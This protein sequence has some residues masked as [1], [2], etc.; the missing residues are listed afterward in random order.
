MSAMDA[1]RASKE[2]MKDNKGRLFCL[3]L[4]YIG[5][6]LIIAIVAGFAALAYTPFGV[7][8]DFILSLFL[9]PYV[10]SAVSAFYLDVSGQ[11]EEIP[12]E[13]PAAQE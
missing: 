5:W 4:S 3:Y 11:S 7:I 6:Y 9:I 13:A 2:M 1:I 10:L 8:V 12:A